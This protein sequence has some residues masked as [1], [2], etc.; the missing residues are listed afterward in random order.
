L[1]VERNHMRKTLVAVGIAAVVLLVGL[2]AVLSLGLPRR[3]GTQAVTSAPSQPAT[4]F[5]QSVRDA[6]RPLI[7]NGTLN[8]SQVDAV[9]QALRN[10]RPPFGDRDGWGRHDGWGRYDGWD[11]R[12]GWGRRGGWG[13]RDGWGRHRGFSFDTAANAIGISTDELAQELRSGRSIADVARS[14]NVDPQKVV[15]ALVDRF[16]QRLDRAVASGRYTRAEADQIL[17]Q[18]RTRI[19]DMVNR[20]FTPRFRGDFWDSWH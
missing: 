16:R 4:A 10:A 9:V 12:D 14:K 5:D 3:T 17:A 2:V 15:D 13:Y 18:E 20:R 19:T 7:N 8:Q 11:R 6:L 1:Y